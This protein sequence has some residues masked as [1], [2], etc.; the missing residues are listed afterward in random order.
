[1]GQFHGAV[2]RAASRGAVPIVPLCVIGNERIPTK[3]FVLHRGTIRIRKLNAV[4]YEEYKDMT[5]FQLKN[6][7]RNIIA[8]ELIKMKNEI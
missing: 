5:P 3:K 1:M 4:Y 2:F 6:Y 8:N 7:I